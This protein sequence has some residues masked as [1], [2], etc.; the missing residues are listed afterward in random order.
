GKQIICAA[1]RKLLC[2]VYGVLKS[3]VPFNP[4]LALAR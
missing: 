2:I 4:E 1:M 3:G